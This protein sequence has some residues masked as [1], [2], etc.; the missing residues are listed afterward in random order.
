[1]ALKKLTEHCL[2]KDRGEGKWKYSRGGDLS[3]VHCMHRLNH[4]N[5]SPLYY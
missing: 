1:M 4:H 5:E 2:K 3:K